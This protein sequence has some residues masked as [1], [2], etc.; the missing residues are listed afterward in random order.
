MNDDIETILKQCLTCFQSVKNLKPTIPNCRMNRLSNSSKIGEFVEIDFIG[1]VLHE[2][3]K[4]GYMGVALENYFKWPVLI[5]F[6]TC[7]RHNAFKLPG[8][9]CDNILL[10]VTVSLYNANSLKSRKFDEFINQK[11]I[12]L[13]FVTLYL[14]TTN[15][16]VE[17]HARTI[18]DCMKNFTLEGITLKEAVKGPSR[19]LR[20]S[21]NSA[22]QM[23]PFEKVTGNKLVTILTSKFR[24]VYSRASLTKII[25]DSNGKTI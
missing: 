9:V 25:K 1:P 3:N 13:E 14:H 16:C 11:K 6:K 10:P 18:Q 21:E 19:V 12:K 5:V 17:R 20:F 23:T 15:K 8:L 22:I 2:K 24:L 4:K 7:S